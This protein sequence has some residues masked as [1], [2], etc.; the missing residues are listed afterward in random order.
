MLPAGSVLR[1]F[2]VGVCNYV[3]FMG[4]VQLRPVYGESAITL[5]FWGECKY[6]L[7]MGR[8][9]LRPAYGESAI[10]SCLWGECNYGY[11]P[12]ITFL[13]NLSIPL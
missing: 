2:Q 3:V 10:M 11:Q 4:R 7:L 5:C 8:V 13:V 6:V 1:E 9:Q 12:L